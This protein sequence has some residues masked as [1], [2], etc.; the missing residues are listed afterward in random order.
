M[1]TLEINQTKT[2]TKVNT[3]LTENFF[4]GRIYSNNAFAQKILKPL[5][6]FLEVA[7]Y[8]IREPSH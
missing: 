3:D 2:E 5:Y 4:V 6:F 8:F 1:T 7:F